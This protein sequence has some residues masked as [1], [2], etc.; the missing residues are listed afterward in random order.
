MPSIN[1]LLSSPRVTS[2][3][4]ESRVERVYRVSG[5]TNELE[6]KSIAMITA[7]AA[8]IEDGVVLEKIAFDTEFVDYGVWEIRASYSRLEN[9]NPPEDPLQPD[10]S[11]YEFDTTGGTAHVTQSLETLQSTFYSSSYS[12]DTFY[13]A[14]NVNTDR[15]EVAG[16]DIVLPVY[17]FSESHSLLPNKVTNAYKGALFLLTGKINAT[18]FKG[19]KAGEVLF[20]GARGSLKRSEGLW[21]MSYQFAA[22]PNIEEA[23]IAGITGINKRGWD[24]LWFHYNRYENPTGVLVLKPTSAHVEKM[25]E[26]GDFAKLLI[27]E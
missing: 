12:H 14:I 17:A 6:A 4:K 13:G 20:L 5:T 8:Q 16:T 27:G 10:E 1:E 26:E 19:F 23:T 3:G 24:Y 25:Y 11:S 7:P 21:Q 18:K 2:D 15:T 9:E 22:S